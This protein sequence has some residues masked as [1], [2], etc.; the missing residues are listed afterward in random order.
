MEWSGAMEST[1][2]KC[3]VL[4]FDP[5]PRQ[6]ENPFSSLLQMEQLL[7]ELLR[8]YD[9][10]EMYVIISQTSGVSYSKGHFEILQHP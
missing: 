9:N 8:G 5:R 1:D 3:I 6:C 10:P 7:L 2:W 4:S